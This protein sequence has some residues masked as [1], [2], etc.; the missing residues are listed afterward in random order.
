MKKQILLAACFFITLISTSVNLYAEAS[1]DS[2][3]AQM[4]R[5]WETDR[6]STRLNSGH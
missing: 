3:K 4:V 6:K 1:A 5:D 2:L